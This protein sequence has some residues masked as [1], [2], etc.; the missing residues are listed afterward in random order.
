MEKEY[1]VKK[2]MEKHGGKYDYRHLPSTFKGTD[3]VDIICPEHGVFNQIARNHISVN[4]TG[5]PICGRARAK[6]KITDTFEEFVRKAR[7]VHGDKYEPIKETFVKTAMK[8]KFKCNVCGNTFEQKG[9]MHLRGNGCS[10]CNPAPKKRTTEEFKE[11]MSKTHPNL[12]ILTEYINADSKIKVRCKTH[13]YTYWTTPHRLVQGMNCQKC[14]DERRGETLRCDVTSLPERLLSIHGDKYRFPFIDKEYDNNKSKLTVICG[15]HGEFKSTANKLLKG[16]GCRKCADIA[17]GLKKRTPVHEVVS[18]LNKLHNGKYQ[19]P[20]IEEEYK[21]YSSHITVVCPVHGEYS[22]NA[23][24][25]LSGC[26]CP[27]CNESHLEREIA[28]ILPDA[29][30]WCKLD[31]LG[32]QNFDF[33]LP[34]N[35]TAIEC[36]GEQ[37]FMEVTGFGGAENFKS[38][39]ERDL[40]KNK[41]AKE[42]DTR[43]IYVTNREYRKYLNRRRFE[44]IY[45]DNVY[46]IEDILEDKEKFVRLITG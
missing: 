8:L 3:K 32:R 1:F 29:N 26:G 39:I 6:S 10:F 40:R 9:S 35:N 11:E 33:Y 15:V 34:E 45:D 18:R 44:G 14:Y 25:H 42:N 5:C 27:R 31:W 46:F 36:Q 23:G 41:L 20:N 43:L 28:S 2:A 7:E 38:C 4:M 19:Y 22:Q 37:H 16:C 30:R 24:S 12:E 21:G 17:N 13:D